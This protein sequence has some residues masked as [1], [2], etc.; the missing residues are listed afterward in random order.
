MQAERVIGGEVGGGGKQEKE[1]KGGKVKLNDIS[2]LM[3]GKY[4]DFDFDFDSIR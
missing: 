1:G 4:F 2:D 3:Y